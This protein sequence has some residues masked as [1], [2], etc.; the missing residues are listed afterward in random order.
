MRRSAVLF[1][2]AA[3]TVVVLLL[4]MT[5]RAEAVATLEYNLA[6]GDNGIGN[7]YRVSGCSAEAKSSHGA[8]SFYPRGDTFKIQDR[9]N[10]G[11]RVGAYWELTDGSRRGLCV[12]AGGTVRTPT[13]HRGA[14]GY[15]NK[16]FPEG[17]RVRFK[18]GTCDA[19]VSPC[20][21]P[22]QYGQWS[23][24]SSIGTSP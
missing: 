23:A 5:A 2:W 11:R 14:Y 13:G 1:G 20:N 18:I 7:C 3:T 19:D 22:S 15:C 10:D 21:K 17:K 16:N 8:V 6:N 24:Y 12:R 4:A 9:D